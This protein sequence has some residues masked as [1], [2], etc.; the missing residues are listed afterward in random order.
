MRD[1]ERALS[2]VRAGDLVAD[3]QGR[4]ARGSAGLA[5]GTVP[6]QE[7]APIGLSRIMI[8]ES[9]SICTAAR[10]SCTS[11][12]YP[13]HCTL[14]RRTLS[15]QSSPYSHAI[16]SHIAVQQLPTLTNDY[17]LFTNLRHVCYEYR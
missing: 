8:R 7:V 10:P 16:T 1:E 12:S 5:P 9:P 4:N 13:D 2:D 14:T 6:Y 3:P 11:D 17:H 15:T